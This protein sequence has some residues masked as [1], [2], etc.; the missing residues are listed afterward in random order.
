[1]QSSRLL[2]CPP[3]MTKHRR[4]KGPRLLKCSPFGAGRAASTFGAGLG[5]SSFGAGRA[6][7]LCCGVV[8]QAVRRVGLVRRFVVRHRA[9]PPLPR[10]GRGQRMGGGFTK[11]T[12]PRLAARGRILLFVEALRPW[13]RLSF[14]ACHRSCWRWALQGK[15]TRACRRAHR[16]TSQTRTSG[17]RRHRGRRCRGAPRRW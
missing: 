9:S 14:G 8:G 17:W 2:I 11:K 3:P 6:G 12:P 5:A 13:P 15:S 7:W 1:M 4:P 16:A 10:G